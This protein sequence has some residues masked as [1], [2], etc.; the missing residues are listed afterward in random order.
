MSRAATAKLKRKQLYS[1]AAVST[2]GR[3]TEL[4]LKL[5]GDNTVALCAVRMRDNVAPQQLKDRHDNGWAYYLIGED[6]IIKPLSEKE[7]KKL[8]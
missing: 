6:G 2:Y 7:V 1:M 3:R 5:T 8:I 4:T